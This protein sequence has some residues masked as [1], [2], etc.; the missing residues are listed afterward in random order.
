LF[1]EKL[2]VKAKKEAVRKKMLKG[3]AT[4]GIER[5]PTRRIKGVEARCS[6]MLGDKNP[7]EKEGGQNGEG[8]GMSLIPTKI[9]RKQ[10]KKSAG[11]HLALG[12][13]DKIP[14]F[15][16]ANSPDK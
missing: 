16:T 3:H 2:V 4:K 12:G 9:S 8:A 7:G 14:F 15:D 11:G 13:Q 10:K 1:P 5:E 6:S